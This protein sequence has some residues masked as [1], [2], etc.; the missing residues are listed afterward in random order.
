M[1]DDIRYGLHGVGR[2]EFAA[3]IFDTTIDRARRAE[4]CALEKRAEEDIR[5]IV[6]EE[7][8]KRFTGIVTVLEA[9]LKEMGK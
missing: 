6:N 5:R 2:I 3:P 9:V 4:L 8:N 7:L 1:S